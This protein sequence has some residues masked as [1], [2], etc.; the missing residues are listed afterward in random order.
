M[1]EALLRISRGHGCPHWGEGRSGNQ[2]TF[3][4]LYLF[5]TS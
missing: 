2:E 1:S 4:L 3:N 5:S